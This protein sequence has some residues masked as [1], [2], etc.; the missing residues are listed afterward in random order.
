MADSP[1]RSAAV[2]PGGRPSSASS[3]DSSTIAGFGS[4]LAFFRCRGLLSAAEG[5][6]VGGSF[7]ATAGTGLG[8]AGVALVP[9]TGGSAASAEL[10]ATSILRR[11]ASRSFKELKSRSILVWRAR[12]VGRVR[13]FW[14]LRRRLVCTAPHRTASGARVFALEPAS[15]S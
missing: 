2:R 11:A 15:L 1:W 3:S 10:T 9:R 7:A 13:R 8:G 6:S 12:A 5:L 14:P 4:S